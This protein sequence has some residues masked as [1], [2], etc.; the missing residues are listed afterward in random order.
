MVFKFVW[1]D[2]EGDHDLFGQAR[3]TTPHEAD[4]FVSTIKFSRG[5]LNI[6]I[7]SSML[8]CPNLKEYLRCVTAMT[9]NPNRMR[10]L[11]LFLQFKHLV[12]KRIQKVYH[13]TQNV[14]IIY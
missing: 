4:K 7:Q 14:I 6:V 13:F 3:I 2:F 5:R 1:G 9:S 8:F 11:G 10:A 12:I